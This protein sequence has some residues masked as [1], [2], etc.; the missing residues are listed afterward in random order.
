[1][2]CEVCELRRSIALLEE[3]RHQIAV[4]AKHYEHS[5]PRRCEELDELDDRISDEIARLERDLYELECEAAAEEAAQDRAYG[6]WPQA[7]V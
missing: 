3:R 4:L 5:D 7:G 1:M 6:H 2:T